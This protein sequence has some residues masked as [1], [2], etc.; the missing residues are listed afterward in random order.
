MRAY[1]DPQRGLDDGTSGPLRRSRLGRR[2]ARPY[3]G[4]GLTE[5][6]LGGVEEVARCRWVPDLISRFLFRH[7]FCTKLCT[8]LS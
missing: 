4:S 6:P 8:N 2:A 1:T 5:L 3:G 7:Q